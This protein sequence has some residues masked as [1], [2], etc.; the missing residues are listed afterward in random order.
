MCQAGICIMNASLNGEGRY[1]TVTRSGSELNPCAPRTDP[2]GTAASV[3]SR[4]P[5]RDIH[6][7]PIPAELNIGRLDRDGA[8][9]VLI[10]AG[11]FVVALQ[12]VPDLEDREESPHRDVV[13]ER[14]RRALHG[15][16][17]PRVWHHLGH[18]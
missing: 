16:R 5:R 4:C 2:R 8:W 11:I 9:W 1:R 15:D 14:P 10:P 7:D 18:L 6:V 12:G 17:V 13:A 3:R